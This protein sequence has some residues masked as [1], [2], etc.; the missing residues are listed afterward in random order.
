M[1]KT[2]KLIPIHL[3]V[4]SLLTAGLTLT[5]IASAAPITWSGASGTDLNWSTAGNWIGGVAPTSTDDVKFFDDGADPTPLNVNNIVNGAFAGSILSLQYAQS[6]LLFHTTQIDA[7]QTLTVLGDFTVGTEAVADQNLDMAVMGAGTLVVSNTTAEMIV[8]QGGSGSSRRATLDMSYLDTFILDVDQV[9]I[10]RGDPSG[11]PNINRN[12]GW[13]YL[14]KTNHLHANSN[15]ANPSAVAIEVGRSASNNGNGSRL[16]LGQTNSIFAASIGVGME[17]ETACQM[18]FN[19]IFTEPVLYVRGADGVGRMGLWT[20]GDGEGNSGTT[21]SQGTVD[22]SG[23]TVDARVDSM[24]IGRAS[25]NSGGSGNSRGTLTFTAG[26]VDVNTLEVGFQPASSGKNGDG[27]VNVNGGTLIVNDSLELG[28]GVGGSGVTAT[29]GRLNINGGTVQANAI[30]TSAAS[31]GSSITVAS[32]TLI[33]TNNIASTDAP[34]GDLSLTDS[35]LDLETLSANPRVVVTNLTTGG[36]GNTITVGLVPAIASYPVTFSLIKY[37]GVIAGSGFNFTLDGLPGAYTGSLVDNSVNGSVDLVLTAGPVAQSITWVGNIDGKWDSSTKN[38]RAGATSVSFFNNDFVTFDDTATG[39]TTIDLTAT[40]I[41]GS[42]I[43]NNSALSYTF[44]GTGR[45]TGSSALSKQGNGTLVLNNQGA[46]NLGGGILI[47]GGTVQVGNGGTNGNLG[48][49]AVVNNASLSFNRSDEFTV[50]NAISG[51]ASGTITKNGA[52]VLTLSGANSFSGAVNVS[53]GTLKAGSDSALGSIDNGVVISSGATLDVAGQNLGAEPVVVSGSG[54]NGA[55]AIVNSGG[56]QLNALRYVTLA[57]DATF[58]NPGRWDI[59]GAPSTADPAN[60]GLSTSGHAYNLTK[61]G[62]NVVSLVGVTVDPALGD[63]DVQEGIFGIETATT[64]I[65]DPTKTLTVH[66]GATVRFYN[67]TNQLNKQ[68]VLNGTGTNTTVDNGAGANTVIGPMTLNGDCVFTIGG[69]SLTL[70]NTL[71][72]AGSLIKAGGSS[73]ILAGGDDSYSGTTTVSNGTL[74][75]NNVL[76]SSGALITMTNTTLAGN[77]SYSG[78]VDVSGQLQ[79][80]G[81]GVFGTFTSSGLMLQET[82]SLVFDL[83]TVQ[84][85]GSGFNDLLQVNGNLAVNGNSILINLPNAALKAGTYRLI[86]YTGTLS[87]SFNPTVSLGGLSRYGLTLDTSTVGQVNLIVTGSA[88]NLVWKGSLG[89]AWDVATTANW[90]NTTT[91][92]DDLFYQ[93]DSVLLDDTASGF[94]LELAGAVAPSSIT[95][96]SGN[97]YF[98]SGSGKITGGTDL[99]KRGAGTLNIASANDFTGDVRV[100]SGT[101]QIGNNAALGSDSGATIIS[102]G[103]SLDVGDPAAAANA[104]NLALEPITVSGS[105]YSGQGAIV[106]SSSVNQ[107]NAVR[108]VTLAGNTTLGGIGRWDIRGTGAALSTGGQPYNLTKIGG[109]QISLVGVEMDPKLGDIDVQQGVFS[110]ETTTSSGGDPAKTITVQSGATLQLHGLTVPLDK[111]LV[112]NGD[113]SGNTFR[114]NSGANVLAGPVTLNG[115]CIFSVVGTSLTLSNSLAGSGDLIKNDGS[116]MILAGP[117]TYTGQTRINGGTLALVGTSSIAA[118][119]AITMR[120]GTTLDVSGRVDGKLI[121]VNNQSLVG[122]GSVLGSLQ[123]DAGGTVSPGDE[124]F[125]PAVATFTIS[126]TLWLSG[127]TVMQTDKFSGTNDLMTAASIEF[128]GT[129][130]LSDYFGVTYADGDAFKL[131]DAQSYSGAFSSIEP[132]TPAD[133]LYWDTSELNTSGILKVVST[134]PPPSIS[135]VTRAGGNL[136]LAGSGGAPNS[137]YYVLT[138]ADLALPLASWTSLA[139]NTFDANGNFNFAAPINPAAKQQFFL[140]QL[141]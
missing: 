25:S 78:A 18:L 28:A 8:R 10:G 68:F 107:Q 43:V 79:P 22:L 86:N 140:L 109:N 65:G 96:D 95:N 69:V 40:L 85:V 131:F 80:G 29:K 13:V 75:I 111:V 102:D 132:A 70:S 41:P 73:L 106:N 126:D 116:R 12:T 23:G 137:S 87:G 103:A 74:V 90:L 48:S 64:G 26:T 39:T 56:Q 17:K 119:P 6:N 46:N 81:I 141:P 89:T 7:G 3:S 9:I 5:Q 32:G 76:T 92:L 118:S 114:N 33:V 67:A 4:V 91:T 104:V 71:N 139:T 130:Q 51:A 133:G 62:T 138:S 44:T 45:I 122:I 88:A 94:S 30:E 99:V 63:V 61:V 117:V 110:I 24:T 82:A 59:R 37:E 60:A 66:P 57:G 52:G 124:F 14:A 20:V 72:G 105:G 101:L 36:S 1:K 127:T 53:A 108:R 47:D 113:G 27:T 15:D 54:V 98:I 93:G 121:V 97:S 135:S 42:L 31:G 34:L 129:L 49:S 83:N 115:S 58:G 134:P 50:G 136:V 21:S 100:E 120:P 84:T 77:G 128:G 55:G 38:W 112:L 19:S 35:F 16:Y 125:G 11:H 2:T 123:V